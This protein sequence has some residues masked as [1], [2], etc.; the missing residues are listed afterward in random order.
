MA[1]ID[2]DFPVKLVW[3]GCQCVHVKSGS[4]YG[5]VPSDYKS[6]IHI[7][8]HILDFAEQKIR[9]TMKQPHM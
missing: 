2:D 7:L 8:Y 6:S 5:L 3:D 9:F 1:N 4:G